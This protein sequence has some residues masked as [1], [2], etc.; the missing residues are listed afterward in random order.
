LTTKQRG[1]QRWRNSRNWRSLWPPG[2]TSIISQQ[3]WW[4]EESICKEV[5]SGPE[6]PEIRKAAD[7]ICV[8]RL[9]SYNSLHLLSDQTEPRAF[10]L[11]SS[12]HASFHAVAVVVE[13]WQE[14]EEGDG[15][16]HS[17]ICRRMLY[18]TPS[19]LLHFFL[20]ESPR[21]DIGSLSWGG[22]KSGRKS[23]EGFPDSS[24]V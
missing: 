11:W 4:P 10:A 14:E 3:N 19:G 2:H 13:L 6:V 8:P 16:T 9:W 17:E 24:L 23:G 18:L 1:R 5:Q 7:D 20:A 15:P 22:R 21:L 12:F